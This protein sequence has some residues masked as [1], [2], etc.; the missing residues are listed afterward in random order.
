MEE[1]ESFLEMALGTLVV[2]FPFWLVFTYSGHS[3]INYF[4]KLLN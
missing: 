4:I 3:T 2:F 1:Q